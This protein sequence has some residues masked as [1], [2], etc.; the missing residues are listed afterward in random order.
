VRKTYLA[1]VRGVPRCARILEEPI[2][3]HPTRKTKMAVV[4][5]SEGGRPA[6]TEWRSLYADPGGRFSLLAVTIRTGRTHQIRVHLSHAGH[7]IVGDA[8]YGGMRNE[9]D[10][11]LK[12]LARR[13][14]LH[15]A[16]LR[17]AHPATGG[18]LSFSCPPPGDFLRAMLRLSR[19]AQ[20]V[21]VTGNPGSGKSTL[22]ALLA[23][24]GLPA[25]SADAVVR[26]LYEP[27]GDA[28]RMLRARFGARFAVAGTDP[29][30]EDAPVDR[31][32]LFAAMRADEGLRREVMDMVHPMV[33]HRMAV[34]EAAHADARAVV[35]EVPLALETG[36][37][38]R[39]G[40]KA[41]TAGRAGREPGRTAADDAEWGR[42]DV[43]VGVA[44]P[45]EERRAR[46][47][48]T[49]GWDAETFAVMES[50]QWPAEKKLAAC[51]VVA[52]N[53]GPREDLAREARRVLA[54]L[55]G[56]R[57]ARM[58]ALAR[59]LA[60]LLADDLEETSGESA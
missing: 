13:Q 33:R 40:G 42:A 53:S 50:W 25:C 36:W 4:P 19:R 39:A 31:A 15:A 35:H 18:E 30:A 60:A 1:V 46:L 38:R 28:A 12:K 44:C 8:L 26:E 51:D 56:R 48:A 11:L 5:E 23:A 27:G 29:D 54:E 6:R 49:R 52:D 55:A 32:A 57:R 10:P 9:R 43:L 47:F 21:V 20:R 22:T 17:F 24:S 45:L 58:R 34:F 2:G 59:R 16:F 14:L 7:P 3:R 41:D 37:G